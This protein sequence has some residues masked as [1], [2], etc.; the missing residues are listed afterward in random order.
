MPDDAE[1]GSTVNKHMN[2]LHKSILACLFLAAI[3]FT[4]AGQ[5]PKII[6]DPPKPSNSGTDFYHDFRNKKSLD[7]NFRLYG[8][9][10]ANRV[11]SEPEG[12]RITLPGN[13]KSPDGLGVICRTPVKGNFEITLGYEILQIAKP[14][15][16]WGN[17]FELYIE[18]DTPTK[19]SVALNRIV[20]PSGAD[21]Y[22]SGRMRT[23]AKGG[24]ERTERG[25]D[26]PAKG[27]AGQLRISRNGSITVMS[28]AEQGSEESQTLYRYDLGTEDVASIRLAAIPG[29]TPFVVDLR[30]IDLRAR[31]LPNIAAPVDPSVKFVDK[32]KAPPRTAL[33]LSLLLI[34]VVTVI[35]GLW[36]WMRKSRGK[37]KEEK[38]DDTNQH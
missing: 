24:H 35:T 11:K 12:L 5:E 34:A 36:L 33:W 1:T 30:L 17:G 13:A 37:S 16:L 21:V 6:P 32:S 27:N 7:G 29:N 22:F 8:A 10:A 23:N 14:K 28:A 26:I 19:E 9:D 18:T 25:N 31:E 38:D 20:R 15:D 2:P 4:V 3:Q